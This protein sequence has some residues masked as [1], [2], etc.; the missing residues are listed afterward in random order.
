M[1]RRP[2]PFPA[3]ARERQRPPLGATSPIPA[4]GPST[5][6]IAPAGP[7]ADLLQKAD[8]QAAFPLRV[9]GELA[10]V[11]VL[12]ISPAAG[13]YQEGDMETVQLVLR[14]L[15]ANLEMRRLVEARLATERRLAERERLSLLGLVAA[16]L[17]HELKNP[18]SSMK[19]LAQTVHEE[20]AAADP[21]SDQAQDLGLIV[22]QI[23]RLHGVT[24]E[25]LDFARA[26]EG[27]GVELTGLLR[28]T[29]YVL[30]HEARRRGIE[31]DASEVR[32]VGRVGGTAATWQTVLFNLV[33]NASQH[34]PAG[35]VV[36][37][38]LSQEW[39]RGPVR[40][41]ERRPRHSAGDR[42]PDLRA[43][44]RRWQR[45][46]SRLGPGG[47]A[48]ARAG[49][50]DR[51]DQ[52]ARA[53]RL[54]GSAGGGRDVKKPRILVC[55]DEPVARR[56][57]VR[58]LG[59][60]AYDFVECG[61]GREAV[62]AL[63][64]PRHG[65]DLVLLDLRM[66]GM[67]GMTTLAHLKDLA[68]PPPVVVVTADS[69]LRTAI[70]AV[71][72]GAAD[73]I[74]KPYEIDE[75]RFV[76]GKTLESARLTAEN[77]RLKEE[78]K[79]LGGARTLLGESPAMQ[80]VLEAVER[81]APAS[82]SVL[83]RGES[84]TGKELV[85]RRIHERSER[86]RGPF[87]AVNCAAI[88]D[89]LVESE[90]F[91]HRRGAFT[92]A[93][94]DRPGRFRQADNGTLFLDEIGDMALAVQAKLLRV[95]QEGIVEP[96]GGGEPVPVDVRVLAATH[97]DL[98]AMVAEGRFREDLV[99]RLRVVEIE[100]PPLRE[101]EEDIL[102]LARHFLAS[103]RAGLA[104]S[105]ETERALQSYPWPGNVRELA[106]AIERAIIFCRGGIVEPED[107]PREV[108]GADGDGRAAAGP[109]AWRPE[110]DF[111]TAKKKVV[112]RF[113]REILTAALH[114]HGGNISQA[115]RHLGLH[116][117]NLQQK[118]HELGI[119]AEEFRG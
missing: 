78:V 90:L 99:F 19:S 61:D 49:R 53:D 36:N 80:R 60:E 69:T 97:R 32:D 47:P 105:P 106:N 110:D 7:L 51:G 67:D 109:L 103:S 66:P 92:G 37:V 27:E 55:D 13:G 89:T 18:L 15:A 87:V 1:A 108:A 33:L 111:A 70:E 45:H 42:R 38:R 86:A 75:L 24:R 10:G 117:Q 21:G 2:R 43:V 46:W 20:L 114:E 23:D 91:G 79:R 17:A 16:S 40:H 96:L 63:G 71:K 8:L 3:A 28:R 57:A 84:G 74:A 101:R 31:L 50:D 64:R 5:G 82:A 41:G 72:A 88:P 14:Q 119:E 34:A 98:R 65:V 62:E 54:R 83:I 95:L 115:A 93:D 58:A 94:R 30:G 102:P 73:F 56:G 52:R 11:L 113:E 12:E 112:E 116:R 104:L 76:V 107:L 68:A 59:A 4:R 85:A 9:G 35:S 100:L 25:I 22:E 77:R 44:R 81:V 39:R 6:S 29:L 48:G 118:L 26:P